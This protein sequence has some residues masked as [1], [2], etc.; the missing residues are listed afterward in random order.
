MY[1]QTWNKYLPVIRI[2]LKRAITEDQTL[3]LNSS[4]FQ[5]AATVRKT[6]HKF[7]I[8]FSNGKGDNIGSPDI[9]KDLSSVLLFDPAAKELLKQNGYTISFDAKYQLI[10]RR[11]AALSPETAMT[12]LE[13]VAE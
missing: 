5:K 1:T 11:V 9:A 8:G 12:S 6:G 7:T 10:L 4:D 3:Q 13:A 2:L